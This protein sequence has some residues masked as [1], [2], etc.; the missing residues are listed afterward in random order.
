MTERWAYLN[1]AG[2][3]PLPAPAGEALNGYARRAA[4]GGSLAGAGHAERTEQV[5]A[6]AAGLMGVPVKD[7]AFVKNTT[8]GLG[9]VANGLAWDHGDRVVIPAQEFPSMVYPWLAL[10]DLGVMVDTVP[11]RGPGRSLPVEA[12]AEAIAAGPPPKVVATSWVQFGR[13]WRTDLPALARVCHDAG[14][15]LCAD[16]IQGLGVVPTELEAWGVDFAMADA[17][18]WLLGPEGIGV[19]YVRDRCLDLLRPLE[20]GWNSVVHRE[21]WDNLDLV[22]DHGARRLEG[23]SQN[24]AGLHALGASIDLLTAAGVDSVWAHVDALCDRACTGLGDVAGATVLSDRSTGGRSGIVT[25]TLDGHDAGTVSERLLVE[26]V[27]CSPR[28]GGVRVSPHGY[29]TA[30]EIDRLIAAVAVVAASPS[31]LG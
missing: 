8:E 12:F 7:V 1:H 20:P 10:R 19:L 9:F 4:G 28:G 30:E 27:V 16:V 29:N 22:W 2:V 31:R 23:G 11:T 18:K 17:H 14:A 24:V 13:G 15:L 25:F 5:R 6:A 3:T 26:G 21:Q